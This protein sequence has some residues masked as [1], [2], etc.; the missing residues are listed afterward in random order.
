[1]ATVLLSPRIPRTLINLVLIAFLTIGCI[2]LT[3][4]VFSSNKSVTIVG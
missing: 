1:M 2:I 3:I 4:G